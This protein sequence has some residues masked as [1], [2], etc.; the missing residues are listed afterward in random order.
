MNLTFIYTTPHELYNGNKNSGVIG[1]LTLRDADMSFNA[2]SLAPFIVSGTVDVTEPFERNDMCILVPKAGDEPTIYNLL[3]TLSKT[4]WM[5]TLFSVIAMMLIYRWTQDIQKFIHSKRYSFYEYS[6]TE[7]STIIF[8]SFFGDSITRIPISMPLRI[9]I[10]VWCVYSFLITNAFQAKLISSLVRPKGLNDIDT[11]EELGHSHFNI[12][13]P[14]ALANHIKEYTDNHTMS[15]LKDQ[16]L[17]VDSWSKFDATMNN[18]NQT[19]FVLMCFHADLMEK[20]MFDKT[21]GRPVYKI[22]KE[23]L[24][25]F[26]R[27]YFLKLGSMYVE[28]VSELLRRFHEMGF[29]VKWARHSEFENGLHGNIPVDD[30]EDADVDEGNIKVVITTEHLQTSFYLLFIGL[31]AASIAFLGEKIYFRR[32]HNRHTEV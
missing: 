8:Q 22:M 7:V 14:I 2:D 9:L 18:R 6:W 16:L 30:D 20:R 25:T 26:P 10:I 21:A 29:I 3:R 13:Y 5:V 28:Y 12:V 11:I 17:E 1:D 31:V 24:L 32:M 19:A 23:R 27:V 15:I 4:T